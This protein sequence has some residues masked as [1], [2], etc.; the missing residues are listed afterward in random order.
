LFDLRPSAIIKRFGL[1]TPIF[2]ETAAYGHMGRRPGK[3]V[4]YINGDRKEVDLF[5]WEKLDYV[6]TIKEAFGLK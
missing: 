2:Q 1:R 5:A 6:D 4:V 3:K